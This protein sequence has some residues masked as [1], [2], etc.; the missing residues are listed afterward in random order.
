MLKGKSITGII[1]KDWNNWDALLN[2]ENHGIKFLNL[3]TVFETTE[4]LD[5]YFTK[6]KIPFKKVRVTLEEIE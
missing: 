3:D 4:D 6:S 2:I 1:H 5:K